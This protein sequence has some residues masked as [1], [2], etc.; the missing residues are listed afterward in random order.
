MVQRLEL[1]DGMSENLLEAF[2]IW[3]WRRMKC[4]KWTD[5]IKKYSC[6]RK[7]GRRKNNTG[8]DN[9]EE[10][11]LAGQV[12]N[13]ELP[14]ETCSRRNGKWDEDSRQKNISDVRHH[15]DKWTRPICRY[16]KKG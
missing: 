15:H 13:K 9:E 10:K 1:Y 14:A 3:I 12:A 2:E 8:T 4:V 5:K 6:A 7:S 11:K 16:E